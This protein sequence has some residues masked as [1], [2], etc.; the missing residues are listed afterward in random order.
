MN[1]KMS[2]KGRFQIEHIRDGVVL[3]KIDQPNGITDVGLNKILDVMFHGITAIG[4]WYVG[5]IDNA[6]YSTLA[7]GDT[8][9][10]HA[11]WIE[12]IAYDEGTRSEWTEGAAAAKSIT[13]ATALTFTM[14]ASKTIKGIFVSSASDKSGATGTLWSTAAFGSTVTVVSGDLLKI[15]YTVTA[16]EV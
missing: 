7:A 15:T 1:E 5:L 6:S 12:C 2:L 13:N 8:M 9:A 11:G 10:S 16:S 14:N 4:T 3:Q